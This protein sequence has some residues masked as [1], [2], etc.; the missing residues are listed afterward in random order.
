MNVGVY[1]GETRQYIEHLTTLLTYCWNDET[2]SKN[3]DVE[4]KVELAVKL[5]AQAAKSMKEK[6]VVKNDH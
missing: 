5:L 6:E 3:A 1:K 4:R 2:F